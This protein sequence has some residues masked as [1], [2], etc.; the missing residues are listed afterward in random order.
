MDFTILRLVLASDV[1]FAHYRELTGGSVWWAHGFS[2]T[3]AVQAFF[4][5]SG[6]IVTASYE[7][8]SS[9]YAFFVRRMAR[10]YPLYALVVLAQAFGVLLAVSPSS[11]SYGE[12]IKYLMANLAFAN[13]L[14]PTF[15]GFLDGAPVT[16]INPALW[17][18]KIE[19]MFYL[20][21]PVWV[22]LSRRYGKWGLLGMFT[23]SSLFYYATAPISAELAKQLP[24]QLRFFVIGMMCKYLITNTQLI[25]TI[26]R[27]AWPILA[28]AGLKAAQIFENNFP[29]AV[30]QPIFV[31][32]F[33]LAIAAI[34]PRLKNFPD[35][36]FGIYLL[37]SPLIQFSHQAGWLPA[38]SEGLI[39]ISIITIAL[40]ILAS[41][42]IEQPAIR[43]GHQ[44]SQRIVKSRA[45]R[46][47]VNA[48]TLN[49]AK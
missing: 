8:S 33:V 21:I 15:S 23:A 29:A 3:V 18:L 12:F 30:L 28:I 20:S 44:I 25:K 35:I 10:L 37:H 22:M 48:K 32:V 27:L 31:A 16:A 42:L 19:V 49:E 26:P 34:S 45:A 38:D 2:S 14:M 40:S 7:A 9:T 6:W 43:A 13:F 47:L 5:I 4:V 1:V 11:V 36:S 24:G 46:L 39:V 41:Y 17:T